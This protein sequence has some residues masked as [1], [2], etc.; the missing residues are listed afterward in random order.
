MSLRHQDTERRG[1]EGE[2]WFP[3]I[4]YSNTQ[5]CTVC[6]KPFQYKKWYHRNKL[7]LVEMNLVTEHT[8]CRKLRCDL[9]K[10][11]QKYNEEF[12][13]IDFEIFYGQNS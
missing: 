1:F 2:P 5:I 7:G 6:Q 12:L 11:K 3:S 8:I 4:K 9:N 10:L 13:N